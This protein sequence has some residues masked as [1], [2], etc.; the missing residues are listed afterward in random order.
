[1]ERVG[2]NQLAMMAK[3]GDR[4]AYKELVVRME[5]AVNSVV[6]KYCVGNGKAFE[7]DYRS[8]AFY[9]LCNSLK[10]FDEGKGAFVSYA[11]YGM[12]SQSMY[13]I[14]DMQN[15]IT[16][17]TNM[18]CN[19]QKVKKAIEAIREDG[20]DETID[21]ICHYSLISSK[22]T[23]ETALWAMIVA[24]CDSLDKNVEGE[25]GAT[26]GD[27]VSGGESVEEAFLE[28]EE[29]RAL[30][31]VVASLPKRDRFIALHSY[32]IFGRRKM[33]N[34]E[35]AETLGCTPN[36]VVNRKN[37]ITARIREAL[38]EWAS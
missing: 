18:L 4:M 11:V 8:E 36:T 32:G 29:E 9:G 15:Q 22:E 34:K 26:F 30:Y 6:S 37:A 17:G 7:R 33:S 12:N 10:S 21:N 23:V 24:S 2:I 35:I 28:R 19:V 13:F 1:M 25:E 14:R 16:I 31:M 27:F 3:N 38:M 5:G 20:L